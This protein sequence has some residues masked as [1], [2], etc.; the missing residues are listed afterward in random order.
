MRC[1]LGLFCDS[2]RIKEI[3]GRQIASFYLSD[4]L[5]IPFPSHPRNEVFA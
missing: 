3:K 2:F 5:F 1:F 4:P